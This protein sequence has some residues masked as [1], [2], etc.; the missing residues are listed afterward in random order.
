[1]GLV[2]ITYH[3]DNHVHAS[4]GSNT[5]NETQP[6][7]TK[8]SDTRLGV[9]F[10]YPSDWQI[11]DKINRFAKNS[12]ITVYNDSNSFRVMKSQSSSDSALVEK[13]GG[14]KE[15]V[16][17]ILPSDERVVGQIEESKYMIDGIKAISVLTVREGITDVPN[18]GFELFLLIHDD[19]LYIFTYQDTVERS[20]TKESQDTLNHILKTI[21]FMDSDSDSDSSGANDCENEDYDNDDDANN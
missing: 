18:K 15:I 19:S 21:R 16:D 4:V 6:H 8:Y 5:T 9:S 1:M 13:L 14:P 20:D 7:F 10:E 17:I 3:H 11:N 2:T 12:D